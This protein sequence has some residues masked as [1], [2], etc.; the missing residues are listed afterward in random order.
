MLAYLSMVRKVG[1]TWRKDAAMEALIVEGNP[2]NNYFVTQEVE[3][4]GY[5]VHSTY[6]T[7]DAIDLAKNIP[8]SL[9]LIDANIS[10]PQFFQS[11]QKTIKSLRDPSQ[12]ETVLLLMVRGS[13]STI[14]PDLLKEGVSGCVSKPVTAE[15]VVSELLKTGHVIENITKKPGKNSK[16]KTLSFNS[17]HTKKLADE[18]G[19][20]S[21]KQ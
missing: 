14:P 18:T 12:G 21:K 15:A 8:F 9:I 11:T 5:S 13:L 10:S 2:F 6:N 20:Q 19:C 4:L 1:E 16:N 17:S 7:T 3:R